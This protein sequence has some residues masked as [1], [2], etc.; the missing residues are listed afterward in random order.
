MARQRQHAEDS[1]RVNLRLNGNTY[2]AVKRL[3]AHAGT[4]V[5]GFVQQSVEAMLPGYLQL[6][7][8]LD[9]GDTVTTLGEGHDVLEQLR[10]MAVH[11]RA[12]ADRLDKMVTV[13]QDK[14]KQDVAAARE[15]V[16]AQET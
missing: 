10:G 4:T 8:T 16:G 1:Y 5:P 15:A 14:L 12:E 2:E 7:A 3:A 13:W 9:Q 11:A 6:L